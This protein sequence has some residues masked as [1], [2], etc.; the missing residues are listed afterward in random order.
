[1]A[2]VQIMSFPGKQ[3][4]LRGIIPDWILDATETQIKVPERNTVG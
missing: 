3:D 1:M 4:P 2:S